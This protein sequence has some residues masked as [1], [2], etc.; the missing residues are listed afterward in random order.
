METHIYTKGNKIFLGM[1]N[2]I[3]KAYDDIGIK[4]FIPKQTPM[5]REIVFDEPVNPKLRSWYQKAV[6]CLGWITFTTRFDVRHTF[7]LLSY[8]LGNP[9]M[10]AIRAAIHVYWYLKTTKFLCIPIALTTDVP[11]EN[12]YQVFSDSDFCANKTDRRAM[13]G[14]IVMYLNTIITARAGRATSALANDLLLPGHPNV[15]VAGSEIFALNETCNRTLGLSYT[16][17]EL[18]MPMD[19]PLKIKG[20]NAASITFH[21]ATNHKSKLVQFDTK[22]Q[23]IKTLRDRK[24][25][26]CIKV[27]TEDNIADMF[28]K[29][30]TPQTF[31]HLREQ[32]GFVTLPKTLQHL[33]LAS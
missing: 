31:L 22:L 23:W 30:T 1:N 9:S 17:K 13:C 26:N 3:D 15:S 25:F 6:G 11:P 28:T 12:R 18:E 32:M 19:F 21:E 29:I 16:T 33:R 24:L 20:D 5:T 10:N 27:K 4:K 14:F 8:E 2:Y 7:Q